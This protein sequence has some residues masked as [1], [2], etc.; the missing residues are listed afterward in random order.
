[1]TTI[2]KEHELA[3]SVKKGFVSGDSRQNMSKLKSDDPSRQDI[4]EFGAQIEDGDFKVITHPD[5]AVDVVSSDIE[6]PF[7]LLPE[8]YFVQL[9]MMA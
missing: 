6:N 7:A 3:T 1:M 9:N 4:A 8:Q 2:R 5:E